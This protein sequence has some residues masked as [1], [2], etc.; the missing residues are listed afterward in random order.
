M[1]TQL[2]Q[3]LKDL[4]VARRDRQEVD[5]P[6]FRIDAIDSRGRL[7]EIQCAGLAAISRKIQSLL[8][9][10]AVTVV[11]PLAARRRIVTLDRPGGNVI[12]SRLSP[13]RQKLA[14]VF[15]ELV[16]FPVFPHPRLRLEVLLTEQEETRVPPTARSSWKKK[17]SVQERKLVAVERRIRLTSPADLWRALQVDLPG[18]FTTSDLA[19]AGAMPRW[20]AQKA[21]WC[22]RRM[23]FFEVSGKQGNAVVY[24][25][26]APARRRSA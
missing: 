11:K 12:R 22:F 24:A 19:A 7:I 21:A 1:A 23:G 4:Y 14:H 5:F 13:A 25:I 15:L 17:Y 16:H 6:G 10:H 8:N 3:Q 9:E 18:P 26:R 20:L 2:H